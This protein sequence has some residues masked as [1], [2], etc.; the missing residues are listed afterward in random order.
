MMWRMIANPATKFDYCCWDVY[1]GVASFYETHDPKYNW[2][3]QTLRSIGE[4]NGV[5]DLGGGPIDATVLPLM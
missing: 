5:R 3:A 1:A 4:L 2:R